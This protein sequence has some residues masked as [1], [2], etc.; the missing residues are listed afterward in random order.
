M[1]TLEFGVFYTEKNSKIYEH[2]LV[3]GKNEEKEELR[4]TINQAA[5]A[6]SSSTKIQITGSFIKMKV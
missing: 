3:M 5:S 2:D 6:C 1:R 4:Q